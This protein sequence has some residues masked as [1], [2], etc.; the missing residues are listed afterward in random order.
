MMSVGTLV[1]TRDLPTRSVRPAE[2]RRRADAMLRALRCQ[3]AEL[4]VLLCSDRV[5]H[6]LNR[7]Y[8]NADR[9]TDVL[10]FAQS[11]GG[12]PVIDTNLLGDVVISIETARRQAHAQGRTIIAE[13]TFLLA[14]GLLHLL[15]FDH[16]NEAELRRMMARTDALCAAASNP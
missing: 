9:P 1:T 15:G 13:V 5:I 2:V 6:E 4:S 11:E 14:H 8:R 3:D 7:D 10:A 16:R 12:G